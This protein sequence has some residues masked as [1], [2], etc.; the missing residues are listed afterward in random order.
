MVINVIVIAVTVL[1]CVLV[2][3]W[4]AC[5]WCRPWIEAPKWQPLAWEGPPTSSRRQPVLPGDRYLRPMPPA[6]R[7]ERLPFAND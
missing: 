4:L 3:V 6:D 7:T 1:L 2:G 5:P